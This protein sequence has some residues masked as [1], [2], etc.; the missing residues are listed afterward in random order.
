MT[1]EARLVAIIKHALLM[2]GS[3]DINVTARGIASEVLL[4]CDLKPVETP[5]PLGRRAPAEKRPAAN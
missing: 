1:T 5:K 3:P 2:H 4:N